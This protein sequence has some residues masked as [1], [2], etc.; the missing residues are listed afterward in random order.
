[1][2]I[3]IKITQKDIDDAVEIQTK[4]FDE[5]RRLGLDPGNATGQGYKS[6][7]EFVGVLG[8]IAVARF[9]GIE[10]FKGNINTFKEADVAGNHV[11]A[12][13]YYGGRL[14]AR[15]GDRVGP[16][17]F[18]V[19]RPEEKV[20][21]IKGW[22]DGAEIMTDKYWLEG[23]ALAKKL[24]KGDPCWCVDQSELHPMDTLPLSVDE[25]A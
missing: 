16:Y 11:R 9:L 7:N 13:E 18:V 24:R 22:M 10:D 17:I 12:T 23:E 5:S 3:R 8:E 4:I 1:M 20:A 2:N 6:R 21:H 14:L 25:A 19:V 15:R